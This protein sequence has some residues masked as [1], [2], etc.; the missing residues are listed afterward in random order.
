MSSKFESPNR[1]RELRLFNCLGKV[2]TAL[3]N[4]TL[5]TAFGSLQISKV[6]GFDSKFELSRSQQHNKGR[7]NNGLFY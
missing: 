3:V 7:V 5:V 1:R 2:D 4:T 6:K